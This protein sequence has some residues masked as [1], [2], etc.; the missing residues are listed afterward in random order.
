MDELVNLHYCAPCRR[1]RRCSDGFE[2]GSLPLAPKPQIA[3]KSHLL[4]LLLAAF[5]EILN[6][7]PCR[8]INS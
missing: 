7:I 8:S 3:G 2:I 1:L 5:V 6:F 4:L